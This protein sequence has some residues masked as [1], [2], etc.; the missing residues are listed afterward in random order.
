MSTDQR[1]AGETLQ[2][3][4]NEIFLFGRGSGGVANRFNFEVCHRPELPVSKQGVSDGYD[5]SFQF[6]CSIARG[7]T[8]VDMIRRTFQS[9]IDNPISKLFVGYP[10]EPAGWFQISTSYFIFNFSKFE[11]LSRFVLWPS[12]QQQ[13]LPDL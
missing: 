4:R 1:A 11:T 6:L 13:C 12:S 3:Q 9:R 2:Y 8:L 7:H 10:M 5:Y